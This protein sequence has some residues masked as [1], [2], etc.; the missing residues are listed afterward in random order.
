MNATG[1]CLVAR[2]AWD[3]L[4]PTARAAVTELV[5]DPN[6]PTTGK[7]TSDQD[8]DVFNYTTY[9]D[10]IRPTLKDLHF[11]NVN[12]NGN[13]DLPPGDNS[14]TFEQKNTAILK[15]PNSSKDQKAE[16]LRLDGHLVGDIHMPLHDADN[17]D[18]G[19]N[20]FKLNGKNNLHSL[21]DKGGGAWP[22]GV[23]EAQLTKLATDIEHKYP[24]EFFGDRVKDLDPVHWA[25]EGWVMAKQDVYVGVTQGQAASPEYIAKC[26]K[27]MEMQAAL[28]GYRWATQLNVI[29]QK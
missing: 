7:P 1:H 23:S 27:D 10:N 17:N 26:T 4:T 25:R 24:M 13:G 3:Y 6:N 2:I 11:V 21:W 5:A 20:G 14:I 19:G 16:A 15:D 9:M 8:N 28:A 18:H 12:I 29:F 22:N